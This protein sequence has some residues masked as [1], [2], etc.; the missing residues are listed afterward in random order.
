[1]LVRLLPPHLRGMHGAAGLC[2]PSGL[3]RC[4]PAGLPLYA[5]WIAATR[6]DWSA[7]DYLDAMKD[8]PNFAGL[9]FTDCASNGYIPL[10][11]HGLLSLTTSFDPRGYR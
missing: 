7:Q 2:V 9:K 8:V 4:A 3:S 11:L 6:G 5:Y 10:R 1:M